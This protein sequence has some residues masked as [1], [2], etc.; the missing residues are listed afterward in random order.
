MVIP[1]LNR[2]I[3]V[4]IMTIEEINLQNLHYFFST[5]AQVIGALLAITG[6]FVVFKIDSL[7][8]ELF[9]YSQDLINFEGQYSELRKILKRKTMNDLRK[10]QVAN[11]VHGV[12][13]IAEQALTKSQTNKDELE[14]KIKE[15]KNKQEDE[16]IG[17]LEETVL[18]QHRNQLSQVNFVHGNCQAIKLIYPR[19]TSFI[20][21]TKS[22]FINNGLILG[23]LLSFYIFL[24]QAKEGYLYWSTLII[25]ISLAMTS[26][27]LIISYILNSVDLNFMQKPNSKKSTDKQS[28]YP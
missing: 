20:N 11:D 23:A 6:A 22:T 18:K 28:P 15:Q 3:L 10:K 17:E 8:K 4:E 21:K 9:S 14:E 12:F 13:E 1:K 19:I 2:T 24:P 5:S 7:K 26:L 25:G 16:G 27:Y